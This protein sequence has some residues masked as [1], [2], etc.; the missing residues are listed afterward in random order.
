MFLIIVKNV[1][2]TFKIQLLLIIV[3][4]GQYK[5][6]IAMYKS[7]KCNFKSIKIILFKKNECYGNCNLFPEIFFYVTSL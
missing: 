2:I 7:K 1:G 6:A 3:N 5:Q 4:I